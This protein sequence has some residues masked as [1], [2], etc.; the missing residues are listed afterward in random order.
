MRYYVR[1]S[2]ISNLFNLLYVISL[3]SHI[4]VI[5]PLKSI[6]LLGVKYYWVTC[7]CKSYVYLKMG[8]ILPTFRIIELG[9]GK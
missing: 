3:V 5:I 6:K 7:N 4:E 9:L 1:V 2:N 8:Q